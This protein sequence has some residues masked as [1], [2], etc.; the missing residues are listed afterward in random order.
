MTGLVHSQGIRRADG[1]KGNQSPETTASEQQTARNNLR[2]EGCDSLIFRKC[3]EWQGLR[4]SNPR[5]SVLETDALPTEL[6]PYHRR[7][8]TPAQKR[9]QD[10]NVTFC[11]FLQILCAG[12]PWGSAHKGSTLSSDREILPIPQGKLNNRKPGSHSHC[13]PCHET[14]AC[15]HWNFRD[16]PAL[17][18]APDH[19][20][21]VSTHS[22]AGTA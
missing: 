3:G 1:M 4:D 9:N 6:N 8:S 2:P 15:F 14:S 7:R 17:S 19:S 5:P 22:C 13:R 21:S 18:P 20:H 10:G 11:V 16:W 12:A